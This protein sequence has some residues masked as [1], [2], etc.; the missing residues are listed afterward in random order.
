M[1]FN[2]F[3]KNTIDIMEPIIYKTIHKRLKLIRN[4]Y[5]KTIERNKIL[6]ILGEIYRFPKEIRNI[7]LIEMEQYGLIEQTTRT[8]VII[9]N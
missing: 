7:V 6:E 9:K 4:P 2:Q 1:G 5:D 8:K 3:T